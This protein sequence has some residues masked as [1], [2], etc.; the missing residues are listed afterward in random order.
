MRR[1]LVAPAK[2]NLFLHVGGPDPHDGFHPLSS[3]MVF[4]DYGDSLSIEPADHD[5][6]LLDGPFAADLIACP[7]SENLVMRAFAVLRREA[8]RPLPP[9]R[10]V[11]RKNLPV[12]AGLG[13]GSCD[14]GAALRL[15]RDAF[16]L[17]IRDRGLEALAGELGSDGPACFWARPVL[18]TGRGDTLGEAPDLPPLH[19]VLVNPRRACSTAAVYRAYDQAARLGG[20]ASARLPERF[21]SAEEVAAVLAMARNDLE[22]PALSV[23]RDIGD[24]LEALRSEPE[25]LLARLSGSGATAFALTADDIAAEALASRLETYRP[26][27]WVKACLLGGPWETAR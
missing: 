3:L 9:V 6:L 26:D 5:E 20:E 18:A 15:L 16:G 17:P 8:H 1:S 2:V 11:L 13:G 22:V 10:L 25:T 23:C 4:A 27:W 14:A 12:A 7:P 24:V 21:E 19:A